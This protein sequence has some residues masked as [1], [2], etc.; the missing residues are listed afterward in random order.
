MRVAPTGSATPRTH[1]RAPWSGR[2][3]FW[4]GLRSALPASGR[5]IGSAAFLSLSETQSAGIIC[6]RAF[7]FRQAQ[8]GATSSLGPAVALL[9]VR[10]WRILLNQKRL[11]VDL[12]HEDE[13]NSMRCY[14]R[15]GFAERTL[16][17]GFHKN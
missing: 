10:R 11:C 6:L 13:R 8:A 15:A 12:V 2:E 16:G 3:A 9:Y 1:R 7:D 14:L 5:W 17:N 4:P